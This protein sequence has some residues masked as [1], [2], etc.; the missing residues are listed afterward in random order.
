[1]SDRLSRLLAGYAHSVS[2][3]DLPRET[4]HEVKRRVLDSVGVGVAGLGEEAATS[5]RA[6]VERL[7]TPT[8]ASVWGASFAAPPEVAGFA[9]GVA[10]RCLDFN[11]TYLSKEPLHPSDAI[12]AC[13][14]LAEWRGLSGREL[15]TGI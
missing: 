11:D 2:W 13:R 10:V 5:A 1:M 3:A 14:A 8:G 6:Y 12:P 9:N 15:I 7:A 4:V